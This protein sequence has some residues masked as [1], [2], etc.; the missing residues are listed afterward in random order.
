MIVQASGSNIKNTL[1]AVRRELNIPLQGSREVLRSGGEDGLYRCH[2]ENG[3]IV[4]ATII[5]H[6]VANVFI[7]PQ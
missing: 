3:I 2:L 1:A 6:Q 7:N 5:Q 4:E